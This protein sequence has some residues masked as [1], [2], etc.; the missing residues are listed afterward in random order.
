MQITEQF[1]NN[2]ISKM[3]DKSIEKEFLFIPEIEKTI[4][5]FRI[6]IKLIPFSFKY[7]LFIDFLIRTIEKPSRVYIEDV[8][9]QLYLFN[10]E[11]ELICPIKSIRTIMYETYKE[12]EETTVCYDYTEEKCV[13]NV[14]NTVI[15]IFERIEKCFKEKRLSELFYTEVIRGRVFLPHDDLNKIINV[16]GLKIVQTKKILEKIIQLVL[17]FLRCQF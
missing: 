17:M 5:G 12:I 16:Y 1:Y 9:L 10:P 4:E 14:V 11:R 15:S 6:E 7:K 8:L 2:I 3:I 13:E